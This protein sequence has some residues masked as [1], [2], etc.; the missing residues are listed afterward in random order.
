MSLGVCEGMMREEWGGEDLYGGYGDEG[1][2][3]VNK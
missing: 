2:D 3:V 1:D